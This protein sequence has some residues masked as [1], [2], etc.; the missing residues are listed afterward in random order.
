M[1]TL[2]IP[3]SPRL[4][5]AGRTFRLPVQSKNGISVELES[6]HFTLIDKRYCSFDEAWYLY[7]RAPQQHVE[8]DLLI[9]QD[10]QSVST[11]ISVRPLGALRQAF[12]HDGDDWPRRWPL[13]QDFKSRKTSQTLDEE[14][15]PT[16]DNQAVHFWKTLDDD[17]LWHQ[18]PNAEMPRAHFTNVHQGCPQC[19]T[20]IFTHDGFYPWLRS[21]RPI[22][23]RSKCPNCQAVFPSNDLANDDFTSGPFA[24]DGYGYVNGDGHLFLFAATY[25]R[26]QVRAFGAGIGHMTSE[27]KAQGDK[28]SG[29]TLALMLL[30]YAVEV[31]YLGAVPQFRYGPSEGEEKTWNWGQTDW[32]GDELSGKGMLRYCIDVPYI[33]ETL[34]LAYDAVWPLFNTD[35]TL[36]ERVRSLGLEADGPDDLVALIEEMLACQLQC[37]L[38]GGARSNL[39]RVS[40]A[41]LVLLRALDRDDGQRALTWLYD[42]GPDRLRT[43]GVNNFF[44]D[45]TPPESTG[46][47]NSIHIDGLFDLEYQLRALRKLHPTAYPE[48]QFPSLLADPRAA[49][50]AR[51]PVEIATLGRSWLQFGDGSAPGSA[52]QL[53]KAADEAKRLTQ[54]VFHAPMRRE[55]LNR[56][57]EYTGDGTMQDLRDAIAAGIHPSLGSTVHDGVGLAVLRTDET[58]ERTAVGVCYGDA[59]G[60]RHMDL[61]DTQL[62][63]HERV[64]LGD[65]GYPQSWA[66][67][68]D[69]EAH[70][71]THNSGWGLVDDLHSEDV[72]GRGRLVHVLQNPGLQALDISAERWAWNAETQAWY[73]PGVTLR[74]LLALIETD[75]TGAMLID[76]MRI[77]GGSTHWR[78][79]RGCGS[80]FSTTVPSQSL[81]GTLAGPDTRRGDLSNLHHPECAALA[82]MDQVQQLNAPSAWNGTWKMD[83]QAHLDIHQLR[84]SSGTTVRSARATAIMGSPEESTYNFRALSWQRDAS[85]GQPT[86]IDLA[87][88]PRLG[89]SDVADIQPVAADSTASGIQI[90]TRKG[91]QIR[92]YWAPDAD[93]QTSFADGTRLCGTLAAS[94][95][96]EITSCDST[97]IYHS[98]QQHALANATRQATVTSVDEANCSV[99]I[100]GVD[101]VAPGMRMR[102]APRGRNYRIERAEK[103]DGGRW[104]LTLD[105][106]TLL[107]RGRIVSAVGKTIELDFYIIA[108]TG[109]LHDTHLR[110]IDGKAARIQSAYNTDHEHTTVHLY[111]PLKNLK[112]G[113]WLE[114][115]DCLP[116]DRV[117]LNATQ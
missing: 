53:A 95:N 56:A 108:R 91:K 7:L 86:C 15:L 69:W 12:T 107:G 81:A 76:L 21:H 49:R 9:R 54:P 1:G 38:D 103:T 85:D 32:S 115:A 17:T 55:T 4:L 100:K 31:I 99:E 14:T 48:A 62:F 2:A 37:C 11:Q 64:F 80:D 60:H 78:L 41:V 79:C 26:D 29:R 116:G 87:F 58:P 90:T 45:G 50:V 18:L 34:A 13:G 93:G 28:E 111:A 61:L 51:S 5:L 59:T 46:G 94:I 19:G 63:A 105:V 110:T 82:Y 77:A 6:T 57:A 8:G 70:W 92:L 27:F 35:E 20:A 10:G 97:S 40:Q 117:L 106:T 22:D 47:Y 84:A 112:P 96:G 75:G 89:P 114:A 102:T 113:Q 42:Q 68:R 23:Y 39:P 73:R 44:P 104:R 52:A 71:A 30:R 65:L 74:R 25:A 33:S 72:A 16:P 3:W 109:Y 67:I 24:D 88:E 101:E 43:F 36:L 83:R 98:G 66:S